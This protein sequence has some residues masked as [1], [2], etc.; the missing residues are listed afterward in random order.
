MKIL[1]LY[2]S[3]RGTIRQMAELI[4][5]SLNDYQVDLKKAGNISVQELKDYGLLV[6]G[7]STWAD[8]D[9]HEDFD[10]LERDLRDVDLKGIYG[11]VFGSGNSRFRYYCEAVD[12]LETRLKHCNCKMIIKS[13]KSDV[14]VPLS[15]LNTKYYTPYPRTKELEVGVLIYDSLLINGDF[16]FIS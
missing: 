6:F 4:G 10:Q 7:S 9:L 8:G 1:I 13:L 15:K 3:R 5:S 11:A 14:I 12:I 2:A 16:A